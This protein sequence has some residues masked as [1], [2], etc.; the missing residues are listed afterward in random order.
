VISKVKE[1]RDFDAVRHQRWF[2]EAIQ[3]TDFW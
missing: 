2:K 3:S 1:E